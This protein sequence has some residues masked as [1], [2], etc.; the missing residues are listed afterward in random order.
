MKTLDYAEA[1]NEIIL[2]GRYNLVM[3]VSNNE[4][5]IRLQTKWLMSN[6]IESVVF[7]DL[8]TYG[9]FV[10]DFNAFRTYRGTKDICY[11]TLLTDSRE[12][13]KSIKSDHY[14]EHDIHKYLIID[15]NDVEFERVKA[16]SYNEIADIPI[17]VPRTVKN[18]FGYMVANDEELERE[19]TTQKEQ[20]SNL[21]KLYDMIQ[22]SNEL[23]IRLKN[24]M[25]EQLT[26]EISQFIYVEHYVDYSKMI[27][28]I[29]Y[30]YDYDTYK[31]IDRLKQKYQLLACNDIKYYRQ[32]HNAVN[33]ILRPYFSSIEFVKQIIDSQ[34]RHGYQF[35]LDYSVNG[36]KVI[37]FRKDCAFIGYNISEI[38]RTRCTSRE[39]ENGNIDLILDKDVVDSVIE[40]LKSYDNN[41]GQNN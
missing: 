15:E 19:F 26:K 33:D 10:N 30:N 7:S 25:L 16:T 36:K 20:Q 18:E 3:V 35:K 41:T 1:Q 37:K 24:R 27:K 40:L 29:L 12:V 31:K 11:K 4:N 2:L 21:V 14:T 22:N 23:D 17:N 9:T 34:Y 13:F 8:K 32:F 38:F 39:Y 28:N 5:F 6:D